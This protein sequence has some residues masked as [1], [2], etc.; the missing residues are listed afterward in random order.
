MSGREKTM[1]DVSRCKR[2]SYLGYSAFAATN[3]DVNI[4]QHH[5][6]KHCAGNDK[7]DIKEHFYPTQVA[8][9]KK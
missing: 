2:V 7:F 8:K 9:K 1:C 4:C 3:R 6:E 5:W